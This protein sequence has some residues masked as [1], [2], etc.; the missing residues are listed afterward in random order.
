MKQPITSPGED[1]PQQQ[2]DQVEPQPDLHPA[3]LRQHINDPAHCQCC[4][5]KQ[6]QC[7]AP[8]SLEKEAATSSSQTP[9]APKHQHLDCYPTV[10]RAIENSNQEGLKQELKWVEQQTDL[11]KVQN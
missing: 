1:S 7:S 11:D 4:N 5:G 6:E 9:A 3:L 8:K 2:R 10:V